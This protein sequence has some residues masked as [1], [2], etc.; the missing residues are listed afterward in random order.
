MDDSAHFFD[1][2]HNDEE[3]RGFF[4]LDNILRA[5]IDLN[6]ETGCNGE[7]DE[8]INVYIAGLLESMTQPDGVLTS[9]PYISPYDVDIRRYLEKN[10]GTRNEFVVYRDNAD[11]GLMSISVFLGYEHEGSYYHKVFADRDESGRIALYYKLAAGA[12]THLQNSRAI[13]VDTYYYMADHMDQLVKILRKVAGDYFDFIEHISKGSLFHLSKEVWDMVTNEKYKSIIDDFLK[14]FSAYKKE[15]TDKNK[16]LLVEK[17]EEI[18]ALNPTFA[19]DI[20]SI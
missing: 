1:L 18:K 10:P 3:K 2:E 19:F 7:N 13:L 15:R 9:K 8:A 16:E 12:L 5:R 17:A 20:S 14:L 6:L 4:F 11:F